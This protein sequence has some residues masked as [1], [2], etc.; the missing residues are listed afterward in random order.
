MDLY[1]KLPHNKSGA[2]VRNEILTSS[3]WTALIHH[4]VVE[5]SDQEDLPSTVDIDAIKGAPGA[6]ITG[7]VVHW[8][9][10]ETTVKE[11]GQTIDESS[12]D[13]ENCGTDSAT[14]SSTGSESVS[15]FSLE[16]NEYVMHLNGN[17]YSSM[18]PF[19]LL[20]F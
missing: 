2:D 10:T 14:R 20:G 19:C 16:I 6:P 7:Q 15:S 18:Y 3:A 9:L 8:N 11:S 1:N 5:E 13:E 4:A 17:M 12:S